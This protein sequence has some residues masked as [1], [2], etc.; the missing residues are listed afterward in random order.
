MKRRN[1]I[2]N[3]GL[4]FAGIALS[5]SIFSK[6]TLEN[7]NLNIII[8]MSG[9]VLYSDIIEAKKNSNILFF[10]QNLNISVN[11]KTNVKYN[12]DIME[13]ENALLAALA[14]INAIEGKKILITNLNA[15]TTKAVIEAKLPI[16]IITTAA[17]DTEQPYRND[18]AVIEMAM[19]NLNHSENVTLILNLEDT[20]IAHCN[21]DEYAKV[22]DYYNLQINNICQKIYTN[23]FR[24]NTAANLSVASVLGRNN[25]NNELSSHTSATDHYD[26]S[27]RSLFFYNTNYANEFHCNF[28]TTIYDSS[29]L[30]LLSTK[31]A[32]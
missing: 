28:D 9:G 1:F 18:A 3:T 30:L 17:L 10:Q 11:C 15:N 16:Q 24:K 27:A 32:I 4:S 23:E 29:A 25:Y 31:I 19:Q 22:L 6:N 20:D 14:G 13:H 21:A 5:N 2:K 8:L 12:G 7:K 26:E